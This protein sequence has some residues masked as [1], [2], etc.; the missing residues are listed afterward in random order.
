[1]RTHPAT[2]FDDRWGVA[3][4][5]PTPTSARS[6]SVRGWLATACLFLCAGAARADIGTLR[7]DLYHTGTRGSEIF[8][9]HEVVREPLP[10]AGN[11]DRPIDDTNRGEYLFEVTTPDAGRVL[12]SRGFSSIFEE[13][14]ST[15]DA[16]SRHR[17]FH[18]SLRFPA[19]DGPVVVR[20]LRRDAQNAFAEIWR[21]PVDPDDM[22]VNR[23]PPPRRGEVLTIQER[24]DP[25]H[26]VDL[27][28]LGDGYTAAE[29]GRFQD[30]ARRAAEAL[31][32]VSPFRE[33][34]DDFNVWALA[35]PGDQSG[36]SRPSSGLWR[37]TAL[38]TRYDA[39]RSERYVLSFDNRAFRD[40]AAHAPYDAVEILVNNETYGG[41]GIFGLYST[42]S[43]R[44]VWLD[45]LFVHEFAHHFAGLADEYYTSPV[46]YEPQRYTVEPWE[47]NVTALADPE[48]LKW[49]RFATPATPVP[50]PWPKAEYE[51]TMRAFQRERADLRARGRPESEMNALF[52]EV[53][54]FADGL[55]GKASHRDGIGAFEGA[56]YAATGYYRPAMNCLMFTRH[57]AFCPVCEASVETIIDLYTERGTRQGKATGQ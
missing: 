8:A 2:S 34:R 32:A 40:V 35:V 21:T 31:F 54:G 16:E 27:L 18:E 52:R 28:I 5:R 39:F 25:A 30:D 23:A 6:V 20:I 33:R 29:L 56:Y 3:G 49:A 19:P 44:S 55:F 9:V 7:L 50:T 47:P 26:K 10:W 41:G 24:G 1:M 17:T 48:R 4:R 13:W 46:A 53:Q 51:E 22:L 15:E 14:Q 38:G 57:D 43:A 11:P 42:A 12:Y 45:Y 36:V 37:A